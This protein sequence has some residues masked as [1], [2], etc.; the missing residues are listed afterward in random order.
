MLIII[1]DT[2]DESLP[3]KLGV[4]AE[5][6]ED[7]DRISEADILLVRSKT[8]CT[9]EFIDRCSMLKLIIRGGVGVDTIDVDYARSRGITVLNTPKASSIAVAE[10]TMA[11]MLA[12]P[13]HLVE[14]HVSMTDGQWLKKQLKRSELY[15]KTLCL[16]GK[17]N[18]AR[19]VARRSSA[20]GMNV[21]GYSRSGQA[22]DAADM[23]LS[24]EEAVRDADYIS[25]HTP[26]TKE[27]RHL[28]NRSVISFC[29]KTPVVINTSRA[30][31]VQPEDMAEALDRGL[32]SWYASDVWPSD[33][34]PDDYPLL[35]NDRVLMTPH[36]G[37]N[38]RENL[39][40]I[41]DEVCT[42]IQEFLEGGLQ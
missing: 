9:R 13:N 11:F 40:R 18:I 31:C 28:F 37:A 12:V 21:V 15:G 6:S 25:I 7:L 42:I 14:A 8:R 36:I 10:L 41:G 34:P 4:W 35:K 2:F 16:I 3:R 17:G 39:A 27:T 26:L 23:K 33:P 22:S 20:F 29:T 24:I 1:A 19:E 30:E 5:V 32:I 38:S